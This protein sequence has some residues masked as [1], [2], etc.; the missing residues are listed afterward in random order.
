MED[1]RIGNTGYLNDFLNAVIAEEVEED[2]ADI[3]GQGVELDDSEVVQT[4][5]RAIELLDTFSL[6]VI[7]CYRKNGL[8]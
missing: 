1:I 2:I 6:Y 4:A 7:Y 8:I 5:R 3:F